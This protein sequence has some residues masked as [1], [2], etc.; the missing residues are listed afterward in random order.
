MGHGRCAMGLDKRMYQGP[1]GA[2]VSTS[3]LSVD[4]IENTRN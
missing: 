4:V 2:S 1:V 3:A